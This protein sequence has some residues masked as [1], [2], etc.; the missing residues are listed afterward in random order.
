[1]LLSALSVVLLF[2]N[3]THQSPFFRR[4][5]NF[6]SLN[7]SPDLQKGIDACGYSAMTP[8][9]E[10]AIVPARRGQDILA[11]AQTGTGKTAAFAIPILQRLAGHAEQLKPGLP[12]ALILTPTR[13]LAE[14][15]ALSLIHI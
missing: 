11:I 14:Q 7:L 2:G 12:R 10:Q 6:N 3:Q 5:M 8:I 9:Q 4:A 15:L 13:E 1:M